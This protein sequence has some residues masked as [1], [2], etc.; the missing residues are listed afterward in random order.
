[1]Q[2]TALRVLLVMLALWGALLTAGLWSGK[3]PAEWL[4]GAARPQAPPAPAP[5][6]CEPAAAKPQTAVP[7]A[8]QPTAAAPRAIEVPLY[9][10][11]PREEG[12]P[13]LSAVHLARDQPPLWALHCGSSVQL[14]SLERDGQQLAPRRIAS[15]RAP[16]DS[17]AESPRALAVRAGDIDGDGLA[18]LV[19]PVLFVDRTGAPSGGALHLLRQRAEG[20]F[21]VSTRLLDCAPG[22]VVSATL[23]T[24]RG[25]DL[26][27]LELRD[28]RTARAN[29][30]W[31]VHG[32]PSPLRFAQL[33]AGVGA[34]A[35]GVADLDRDGIDDVAVGS[36]RENRV[37]LWLSAH[38]EVG[39]SEPAS[40]DAPGLREIVTGDLD[41]DG[42]ADLVLTGERISALLA[43]DDFKPTAR[44]LL[45]SAELREIQ[46]VDVDQDGKPDIV[47]YAHPE[48]I[49]LH[50]GPGLTFER[51]RLARLQGDVAIRFARLVQISADKHFGLL[52]LAVSGGPDPQIELGIAEDIAGDGPILLAPTHSG[53][54]D[55]PLILRS[56]LR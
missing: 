25:Q 29:E 41:G 19:A 5:C 8:A 30:L 23:D 46:I 1:V 38:G 28:G 12:A 9:P 24:E 26:A 40:I 48:L 32:G 20:G 27:L 11:C 45:P 34:S 4:P 43:A 18:D 49:A 52:I 56:T 35:L 10:I 22:A 36:G 37:R 33:P 21:A 7:A 14:L 15:L 44:E 50:Q 47:G 42:K 6:A 16:S 3:L 13:A 54:R 39:R 55:E 51:R 17:Q 2:V 53:V 31:L